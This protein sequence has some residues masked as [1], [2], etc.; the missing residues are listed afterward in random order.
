MH[1]ETMQDWLYQTRRKTFAGLQVIHVNLQKRAYGRSGALSTV[2]R[3]LTTFGA[4]CGSFTQ[5]LLSRERASGH[6]LCFKD[7]EGGTGFI[8]NISV[9]DDSL[10]E[11]VTRNDENKEV[12]IV[13]A[14]SIGGQV[15]VLLYSTK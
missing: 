5:L 2:L 11:P 8:S 4:R 9:E 14:H 7:S 12:S 10:L 13:F 1:G 15:H 6:L 3:E